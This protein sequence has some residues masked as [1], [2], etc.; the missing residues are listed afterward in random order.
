MTTTKS[1]V[2]NDI[3]IN[4]T[5]SSYSEAL[6]PVREEAKKLREALIIDKEE[7]EE[8]WPETDSPHVL[9]APKVQNYQRDGMNIMGAGPQRRAKPSSPA[10]PATHR[11]TEK[12]YKDKEPAGV[13][14]TVFKG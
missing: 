13:D 11:Y 5:K 3:E 7:D 4:K 8:E 6:D 10:K 9:S 14:H 2:G 1:I 12:V